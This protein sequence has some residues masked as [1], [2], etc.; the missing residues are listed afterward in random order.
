MPQTLK[1]IY[2]Y[3]LKHNQLPFTFEKSDGKQVAVFDNTTPL[4]V[5]VDATFEVNEDEE[6]DIFLPMM[7]KVCHSGINVNET[8]ISDGLLE[9]RKSSIANKPIVCEIVVKDDGS[10]DFGHHAISYYLDENGEKK[11][12]Y[13]EK[14]VGVFPESCNPQIIYDKN[15]QKNYLYAKGYIY[16]KHGNETAKIIK[17]KKGATHVSSELAIYALGYDAENKVLEILDFEF[18]GVC[19]LGDDVQTGMVGTN[20]SPLTQSNEINENKIS[21]YSLQEIQ[22]Q[23]A[24]LTE[25]VNQALLLFQQKK[26]GESTD[27]MKLNELLKKYNKSK[28]DITFEIENKSD[29]ELEKLFEE[30]F[31]EPTSEATVAGTA[32]ATESNTESTTIT[33]TAHDDMAYSLKMVETVGDKVKNYEISL[34]DKQRQLREVVRAQYESEDNYISVTCF[35][36]YVVMYDYN[37]GLYYKQAYKMGDNDMPQL[38][39]DRVQVYASFIT[40]AE[41]D[42]LEKL[43]SDYELVKKKL[44]NYESRK[45]KLEY[46][47]SDAVY[48]KLTEDSHFKSLLED[49]DKYSLDEFKIQCDVAYAKL[50]RESGNF[51]AKTQHKTTVPV[52]MNIAT[53][54]DEAYGGLFNED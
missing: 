49:I 52:P 35:D 7:F 42:A 22:K 4:K 34:D 27:N 36:T 18:S 21:L 25:K 51:E 39:G 11:P 47:N 1:E 10:M 32:T 37:T 40:A 53:K 14:V 20:A 8:K 17:E 5:N 50:V 15:A 45:E 46:L 19:L 48:S 41:K 44:S 9:N 6:T 23:T 13:D 29:A 43:K 12:Y 26:K 30:N 16:K 28:S 31:G 33:E 3:C 2:E 38:T 54:E 24:D